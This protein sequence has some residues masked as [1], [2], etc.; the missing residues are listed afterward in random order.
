M[1]TRHDSA[2]AKTSRRVPAGL[3]LPDLT[4]ADLRIM[5]A[6]RSI[7]EAAGMAE[8]LRASLR[9]VVMRIDFEPSGRPPDPQPSTKPQRRRP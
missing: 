6:D 5:P 7:F 3:R 8:V 9:R 2:V 4:A 1:Q